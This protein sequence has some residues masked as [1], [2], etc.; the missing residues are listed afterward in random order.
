ML[1]KIEFHP[2]QLV[3]YMSLH[4]GNIVI[5]NMGQKLLDKNFAHESKGGA[6][7]KKASPGKK[8]QL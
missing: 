3:M 1:D 8:F 2:T 7:K 4:C 5:T 6:K